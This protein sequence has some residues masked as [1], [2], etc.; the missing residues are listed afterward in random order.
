MCADFLIVAIVMLMERSGGM[1]DAPEIY[2]YPA[3]TAVPL[4][5]IEH[6]HLRCK[7]FTFLFFRVSTSFLTSILTTR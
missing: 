3:V 2:T 7:S 4:V 1:I 5:P 6:V